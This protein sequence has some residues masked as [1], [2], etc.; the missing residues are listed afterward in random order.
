MVFLICFEHSEPPNRP[1]KNFFLIMRLRID[2]SKLFRS[3][4]RL[5]MAFAK[6]LGR[7]GG[8]EWYF[9]TCCVDSEAPNGM[10]KIF[11]INF[12]AL[13]REENFF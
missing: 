4:R 9:Q 3:I 5:R 2:F 7:F 1:N 8:S 12:D 11:L 10:E 6:L 13:K